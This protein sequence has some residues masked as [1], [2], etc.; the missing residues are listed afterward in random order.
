MFESTI[1]P[2]ISTDSRVSVGVYTYGAPALKMW[3]ETDRIRIGAFCSIAEGVSIFGGGEHN[4]HWVTTFPL[5]IAF[6]DALAGRDGHPASKGETVV[7]NDV[8]IG[9]GAVILSGVSVGNGAIIG[10]RA[11]VSRDVPAYHIVAGNP[12]QVVRIRFPQATIAALE[13]IQWWQW[14][15]DRIVTEIPQLCGD[16]VD[17]FVTRHDPALR[18]GSYR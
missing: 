4:T 3:S 5:R 2:L 9:D 13:R 6:G 17:E 8:W 1:P 14:P 11:V 15:I 18:D 7:G 10:A 16:G 12:A